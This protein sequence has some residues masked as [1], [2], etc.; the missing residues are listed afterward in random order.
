MWVS[1]G[2]SHCGRDTALEILRD[3]VLES[4][5]LLVLVGGGTVAGYDLAARSWL[6]R[7]ELGDRLEALRALTTE[8]AD[9]VRQGRP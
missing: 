4:F 2:M 7:P 3:H 6:S 9:G 1:S 5:R 8:L